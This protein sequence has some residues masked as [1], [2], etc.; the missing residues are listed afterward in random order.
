MT[1]RFGEEYLFYNLFIY[2]TIIIHYLKFQKE[3]MVTSDLEIKL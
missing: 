2:N 1:M 3:I